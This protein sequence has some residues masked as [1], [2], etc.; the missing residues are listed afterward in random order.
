M[1]EFNF[2]QTTGGYTIDKESVK[3]YVLKERNKRS[4]AKR[5]AEEVIY[6]IKLSDFSE[7]TKL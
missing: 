2:F 7:F 5:T 1:F 6:D 4:F 3:K